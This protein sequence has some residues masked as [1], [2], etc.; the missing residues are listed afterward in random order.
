MEV[1]ALH[2]HG[3]TVSAL[4]RELGLGRDRVRRAESSRT[5]PVRAQEEAE[6]DSGVA[7]SR[8]ASA[9]RRS[10]A[11][12]CTCISQPR[13][14]CRYVRA[15]HLFA[16]RSAVRAQGSRSRAPEFNAPARLIL[17]L[18]NRQPFDA[19]NREAVGREHLN[20][21]SA[22]RPRQSGAGLRVSGVAGGNRQ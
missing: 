17:S 21:L 3:W 5:G 18:G 6:P 16:L 1:K 12:R 19:V 4:A 14:R 13:P 7:G 8:R 10:A 9:A 11:Y 15:A 2:H 20:L 22:E